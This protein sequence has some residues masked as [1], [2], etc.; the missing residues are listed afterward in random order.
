MKSAKSAS[1]A[2]TTP[3]ARRRIGERRRAT[4]E[5]WR[6]SPYPASDGC[7]PQDRYRSRLPNSRRGSRF[8]ATSRASP[9]FFWNPGFAQPLE[10]TLALLE[11][12]RVVALR[13]AEKSGD[14]VIRR[15]RRAS[16]HLGSRLIEAAEMRKRGGHIEMAQ[17]IVSAGVDRAAKERDRFVVGSKVQLGQATDV[18][19]HEG[20]RVSRR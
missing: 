19:P 8:G 3:S 20:D 18:G 10:N 14:R 6:K 15:E 1:A 16:F 9:S 11:V 13:H 4:W 2:Q 17:R 7:S 12:G 5:P